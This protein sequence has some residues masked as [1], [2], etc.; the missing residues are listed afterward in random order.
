VS[1]A[2]GKYREA[3]ELRAA[4]RRLTHSTEQVTKRHKLTPRRYE[5]LLFVEAARQAGASA[6]VTSLCEPLQTTQGSVTQL[7]EGAV[8]AG[9]LKRVPV[10][11]DRRSSTLHLTERGRKRLSSVYNALGPERDRLAQLVA[12]AGAD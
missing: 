8:R 3:A 5:L 2:A 10:P 1:E 11:S 4:L 12:R 7:V 6:T 9:L